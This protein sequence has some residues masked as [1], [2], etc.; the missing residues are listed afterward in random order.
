MRARTV[1]INTAIVIPLLL[2]TYYTRRQYVFQRALSH[3]QISFSDF[4]PSYTSA[5]NVSRTNGEALLNFDYNTSLP[6]PSIPRTI[7][8]IY[9]ADLYHHRNGTPSLPSTSRSHAPEL[10]RKFNP[11]Y[12]I[13]I[14][15]AT[16]AH[17][18][19]ETEYPWFLPTYDGYTYPIQCVDA[20]KY[21]ALYHFGGVY[22]DLDIACRRPLDPLLQFSA[23]W[24]EASPLGVN[25]DLMAS[26]PRHPILLE[27][28]TMLVGR[29][30]NLV[31][32]YLTIFWST[33]PQFSSDMLKT[34]W[35][36]HSKRIG[37]DHDTASF[38]ILPRIFYSEEY[39]FFG[40]SPGGTWHGSDV[41][42]VLWLVDRPWVLFCMFGTCLVLTLGLK[43]GLRLRK[44]TC[45]Q[46]GILHAE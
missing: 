6:T 4:P 33:G 14:W 8:F 2:A 36:R 20:L 5:L 35:W 22:M 38:R 28:T 46:D 44:A 40:H 7:H 9:F 16:A 42:V 34:W 29:N 39:T 43:R 30:W 26:A 21:F 12:D 1:L 19:I 17:K 10:C 18:F 25:N 11:T 41:A 13:R 23:W 15:N 24:P 45:K 27:M 32:P 37:S 3:L 31:F